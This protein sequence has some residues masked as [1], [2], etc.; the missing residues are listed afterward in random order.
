MRWIVIRLFDV[1]GRVTGVCLDA[2]GDS[3][4][5][6]I[7]AAKTALP[8]P[9][10]DLAAVYYQAFPVHVRYPSPKAPK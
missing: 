1:P 6:A 10:P 9:E 7:D 4:A 8:K 2:E 3:H 5:E